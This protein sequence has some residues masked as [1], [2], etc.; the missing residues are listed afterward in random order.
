MPRTVPK[1]TRD[2]SPTGRVSKKADVVPLRG[3]P[4]LAGSEID[5]L[6]DGGAGNDDRAGLDAQA[7]AGAVLDVD[8]QRVAGV[9]QPDGVQR[10]G[11]ELLRRARQPGLVVVLRAD[12]AV[13]AD[14][15]AVAALDAAPGSQTATSSEMFRFSYAVVPLG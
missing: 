14:E 2:R 1:S 6:G 8:L 15:A 9:R 10:R 4:R 5:R 3:Q 12:H 13:R 11:V 7:A